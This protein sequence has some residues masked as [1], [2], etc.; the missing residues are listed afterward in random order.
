MLLRVVTVR[1]ARGR[2]ADYWAWAREILTY[3]DEQ[4]VLRAGGPYSSTLADGAEIAT[5]LTLHEN[6]DEIAAEFRELYAAGRGRELI[7]RRPPLVE[8]TSGAILAEW[9]QAATGGPPELP[10][11]I[12]ADVR[13]GSG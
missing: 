7:E 6:A 5:W 2:E 3:W 12:P 11:T 8:S 1:I 9:A 13:P 4:G 10:W